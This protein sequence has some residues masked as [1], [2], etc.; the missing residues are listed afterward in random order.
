MSDNEDFRLYG[1]DR[2][3]ELDEWERTIVN[4]STKVVSVEE[5][6]ELVK[7]FVGEKFA[8]KED[9]D[10]VN[11]R[12]K[13]LVVWGMSQKSQNEVKAGEVALETIKL[14]RTDAQLVAIRLRKNVLEKANKTVRRI[15]M[16]VYDTAM[17]PHEV[18]AYAK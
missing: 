13:Q 2:P 14:E 16:E 15:R 4:V 10:D 5:A 7:K 11:H 18:I 9:F 8:E 1:E 12:I 17:K 3:E 6:M